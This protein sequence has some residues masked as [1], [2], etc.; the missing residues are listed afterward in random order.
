MN[1]PRKRCPSFSQYCRFCELD[2]SYGLCNERLSSYIDR[3]S[4]VIDVDSLS[5]SDEGTDNS[6][7]DGSDP[8]QEEN[9][10]PLA[11]HLLYDETM[12]IYNYRYNESDE[13]EDTG[14]HPQGIEEPYQRLSNIA[15]EIFDRYG[16]LNRDLKTHP[17]R[18]GTGAW[19]SEFDLESF[20]V[21]ERIPIDDEWRRK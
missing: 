7:E 14:P 1:M 20:F 21:I 5:S 10:E 13:D 11:G 19:G 6:K 15:F 17:I 9:E 18:K 12:D 4:S 8:G 16:R 2:I 3:C